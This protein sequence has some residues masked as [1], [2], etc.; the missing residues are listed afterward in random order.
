MTAALALT[1]H[2]SR[3]NPAQAVSQIIYQ[4]QPKSYEGLMD[5]LDLFSPQS[6]YA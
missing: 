3:T 2:T 1:I 6:N 5:L 4:E